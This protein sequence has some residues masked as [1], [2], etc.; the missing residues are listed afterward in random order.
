MGGARSIDEKE[1]IMCTLFSCRISRW[2]EPL[3]RSRRKYE[4]N[5][6]IDLR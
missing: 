3:G 6:K 5:N 4:D 2:K 1:E